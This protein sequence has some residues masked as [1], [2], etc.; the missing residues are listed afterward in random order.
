MVVTGGVNVYPREVENVIATLPG[1]ADV[2]VVGVPHEEWG[3]QLHAFI[4]ASPSETPDEESVIAACRRLL[5]GFK[6][7]RSVSF[8]AALPRNA[9]GKVLKRVLRD[10]AIECAQERL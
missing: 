3:E 6:T 2:A 10:T 5:A 4:V 1:V 7:P 8:I 9:S